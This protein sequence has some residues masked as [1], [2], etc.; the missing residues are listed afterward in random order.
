MSNAKCNHTMKKISRQLLPLFLM[1]CATATAA[2]NITLPYFNGFEDNAENSEWILNPGDDC[3]DKWYISGATSYD[4]E[5]SMY[6]SYWGEDSLKFG[7]EKNVAVAYREVSLPQGAYEI[8][9]QWRNYASDS[10]SG[11][12]VSVYSASAGAAPGSVTGSSDMEPLSLVSCQSLL[13]Q[14]GTTR[15]TRLAGDGN[16][17]TSSFTYS[18]NA[19]ETYYLAFIWVNNEPADMT[20][21]ISTAIDNIQIS[22]SS[23]KAPTGITVDD[24][25]DTAVITWE[26]QALLYD[27]E[28]RKAGTDSWRSVRNLSGS[29]GSTVHSYTLGGI[30]EGI[31]DFRIRSVS[32]VGGGDT[33]WSAYTLKY[34]NLVFCPE[35]HCI[36]YID[37]NDGNVKCLIGDAGPSPQ[38][39]AVMPQDFGYKDIYSRHTVH[40]MAGETDIH[41]GGRLKTIPD[42]E[43]ASVRIGNWNTGAEADGIE[44]TVTISPDQSI[45]L[46][47][48][49]I[50]FEDPQHP[51]EEQPYFN[52]EIYDDEGRLIDPECG[53]ASF[54]ADMNAEGWNVEEQNG[55][56]IVWK[57]WTTLGF[58]LSGM[59]GRD[60][61]IRLITQDCTQGA[62]YGYAYFTLG[63]ASGTIQGMSC[64]ASPTMDLKAPDG[65]D[66][67]W[68]LSDNMNDTLS[69][70]QIYE[71]ASDDDREYVCHCLFKEGG[72]GC[73]F[74]L[75]TKVS[76]RFPFA[77]FGW[78]HVPSDCGNRIQLTDQSHVVSRDEEGN[79][80]HTDEEAETRVW[81]INGTEYEERHPLLTVP[82]EGGEIEIKLTAG[83]SGGCYDDT[84]Y[85]IEVPSILTE[86]RET[87]TT[88]CYG[89][90]FAFCNPVQI[91]GAVRDTTIVCE[92]KNRYGCD[93][94][95]I[96][97]LHVNPRSETTTVNDTICHGDM[98]DAGPEPVSGSGRYEYR[99][100]NRYGCD[101]TVIVNVTELPEV[102]FSCTA[103]PETEPRNGKIE[104][105][106][107]EENF[108]YSIDG[109]TGGRLD[110]LSGREYEIVVFNSHGCASRPQ[111]VTVGRFCVD[112]TIDTSAV[113]AACA[114]D[115]ILPVGYTYTQGIPTEYG[116][117]YGDKARQAGFADI[118][119]EFSGR[120]IQITIPDSCRPD[121]YDA[122][123]FVGDKVCDTLYFPI[124]FEIH[125]PKSIV[126]QKWN[127]VLAVTNGQYNGGYTFT[128]FQWYKD[129][130]P[131]AGETGSYL[132]LGEGN[133][134]DTAALYH[135]VLTR[136]EDGITLP[137]CPLTPET[138]SD[139]TQYPMQTEA[140]VGGKMMIANVKGQSTARLYSVSG[141]LCSET[142]IDAWHNELTVPDMPGVYIL[143][144]EQEGRTTPYKI[145]V[146]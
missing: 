55:S 40:W 43:L 78:E 77:T 103:E 108:R 12:Y 72:E 122:V 80:V 38:M 136:A 64:G 132:Y 52:L 10:K 145:L 116:I 96:I 16:W 141:I 142:E 34:T 25:C 128:A 100:T 82:N 73:Q 39:A 44:Y 104:I 61:K 138:R 63:C 37:L 119:E 111:T 123:V 120:D 83:I 121:I 15:G 125:Y 74:E 49:A 124:G 130:S 68:F 50:V 65:F 70:E 14:D 54:Y 146:R 81:T 85:T 62:H 4:G 21:R 97:N 24:M 79:T 112:I 115:S 60:V 89:E 98:S 71:A 7:K 45:L 32:P 75:R 105:T 90:T 67:A 2:Q 91:F 66:Y 22:N 11:L 93:S 110:S 113:W 47:K 99:L 6:I 42:G 33:L 59:A 76:P 127:N 137:T 143:T 84:T 23:A 114:D 92:I 41:T 53:T 117:R 29:V 9:F 17:Y 18:F 109:V 102:L 126:R 48:Y 95:T 107:A 57:D 139:A 88:L 56:T 8:T 30:E 101:S 19:G 13:Q 28:W 3:T 106:C 51:T 87:D 140:T 133:T 27:L 131:I 144:I 69:T 20:T 26:G 135:A 134:L 118:R 58:D 94:I 86:T 46:L 129:G 35:N 31:Y 36:N 5:R 1:L